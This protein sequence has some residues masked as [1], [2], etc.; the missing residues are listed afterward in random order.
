MRKRTGAALGLVLFLFAALWLL[1]RPHLFVAAPDRLL[2]VI[3]AEAG[4]E[5]STRFLHSVQ[6]T[7]VEEFFAVDDARRG[8][9]LL[10]T[11][12][13]SFGVGLPFLA[14]DGTFRSEDGRFLME[15]MNRPFPRLALRPGV[16]TELTLTVGNT[17]YRLYE[18]APPGALIQ[19]YIA[20]YYRRWL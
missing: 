20:P 5:F 7:P 19:L 8:F 14:A 11:R 6:K 12:Y 4:M 15:D 10:R 2:A 13:Q 17:S 18:L 3:P 9:I 16:G 1:S